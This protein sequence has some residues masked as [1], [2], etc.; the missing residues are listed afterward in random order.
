[1]YVD[2]KACFALW[3]LYLQQL[4]A[5]HPHH[6]AKPTAFG[7]GGEP[8]LADEL[9][10]LVLAGTKRATTSLPLEYTSQGSALP[11]VGDASIIARGDGSPV[12][13][14][15]RTVI[16]TLAFDAVDS[17]FAAIEGEGDGSL[18]FWRR[19]HLWYFNSVCARLGGSFDGQTPVMCE[20]FRVVWPQPD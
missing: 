12:A 17:A 15:E 14:I 13:I 8:G 3:K 18:A 11:R 2:Y 1:M 19:A 16:T 20:V 6:T 9:A 7:F 10:A 4:P 5:D